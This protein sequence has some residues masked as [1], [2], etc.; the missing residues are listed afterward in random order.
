[1]VNIYFVPRHC[2]HLAAVDMS[3][4]IFKLSWTE[5]SSSDT[6]LLVKGL[7]LGWVWEYVRIT[8]FG[9]LSLMFLSCYTPVSCFIGYNA[10]CD[11]SDKAYFF[12]KKCAL[13]QKK[14]QLSKYAWFTYK[15]DRRQIHK[16]QWTVLNF[17]WKNKENIQ[18]WE[19]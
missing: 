5:V 6:C 4:R 11:I 19:R 8:W 18:I 7:R 9:D 3:F 15:H 12:R 16:G 13:F 1:M 10:Q 2:F 17:G 14:A